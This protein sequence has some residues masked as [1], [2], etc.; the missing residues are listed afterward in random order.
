MN[1]L[2]IIP[3]GRLLV[4]LAA[5]Y[6]NIINNRQDRM[7]YLIATGISILICWIGYTSSATDIGGLSRLSLIFWTAVLLCL[8]AGSAL[9]IGSP[10]IISI[11]QTNGFRRAGLH[12]KDGGTPLLVSENR[13]DDGLTR[14]EYFANGVPFA[15]FQAKQEAI[16]SALNIVIL[17]IRYGRTR[18][19][20]IIDA[21]SGDC[22][23]PDRVDWTDHYI[24]VKPSEIAL[25]MTEH[26]LMTIDLDATPHVQCGGITGSGKT[27]LLKSV[28]HQMHR[29]GAIVYLCDFKGLIDFNQN[30]RSRYRCVTT[31]ENLLDTLKQLVDEMNARK[32]QF[33]ASYCANISEYN[34]L[35][36]EDP[37]KRIMLASDEIAFAFQKKGLTTEDK[38]I[39]AEIEANMALLA[40]QGRFAGIHL[41]LSTQRGD[42]DTIPAQIR[43]NLTVRI[44][45][46][47]SDV[48]SRV[49]IDSS[50][51]SEIPKSLPGRFVDDTGTFFQSFY[52]KEANYGIH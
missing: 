48:L 43:S 38:A 8:N 39:V 20:I 30:E 25:G 50:I 47:A 17:D 37:C 9:V 15:E 26:G 12:N 7:K 14:Y 44:C 6:R 13:T 31:K 33:A 32:E 4:W 45:G 34:R 41:W 42:A 27:I 35:H 2:T 3:A 19:G 24:P 11:I 28:L 29:K 52:Y 49:T 23:L 5:G 16:E 40:Q 21:I 22:Q 1:I 10:L 51:A 46:R 18:S 36:P